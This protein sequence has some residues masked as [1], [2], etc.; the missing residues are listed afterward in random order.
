MCILED[1]QVDADGLEMVEKSH[2]GPKDGDSERRDDVEERRSGI[3][4]QASGMA[5]F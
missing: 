5:I 1:G 2:L 4:L 3:C